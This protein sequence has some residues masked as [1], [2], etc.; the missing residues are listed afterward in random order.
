MAEA[1]ERYVST[2]SIGIPVDVV[3]ESEPLGTGGAA[4]NAVLQAGVSG[5]KVIVL[6]GDAIGGWPLDDLVASSLRL[7]DIG[8][9]VAVD[10]PDVSRYGRLSVHGDRVELFME[11]GGAGPGL[12]NGG[13]YCLDVALLASWRHARF[14]LELDVL[15]D[16][17]SRRRLG[18]VRCSGPFIDI[19]VPESFAEGQTVVGAIS[20]LG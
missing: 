11:K 9:L 18:L 13:V 17:A 19:G 8:T 2:V 6:N 10:V 15:T 12:V 7:G 4:R 20:G 5:E 1:V 16:L 3:A 14:S